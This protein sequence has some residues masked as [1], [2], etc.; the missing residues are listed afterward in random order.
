MNDHTLPELTILLSGRGSN[1]QAIHAAC[2]KG[3]LKAR[4]SHVISNNPG[5]GGLQY[6]RDHNIKID[7]VDH[8]AYKSRQD[9]DQALADQITG[10]SPALILLAGFMRR[11]SGDFTRKFHSRLLNIHPSLLPRHPGLNTHQ[12]AID[13]LDTWHGCS[14]HFVTEELDGGPIIARSV[15]PVLSTD[16]PDTLAARVLRK[17]H[18]AYWKAAQMCLDNT[19][20]CQDGHIVF[21]GKTLNYPI[22]L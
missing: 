20:E 7:V 13:S 12:Q 3:L 19:I 22:L 11:L 2:Q 8:K 10:G 6:A 15:V 21:Q 16:T 5:A 1:M 17:E 14:I 9:F 18:Q 4:V